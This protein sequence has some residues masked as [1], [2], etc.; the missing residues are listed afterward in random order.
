MSESNNNDFTIDLDLHTQED[1]A[2]AQHPA[3]QEAVT[4]IQHSNGLSAEFD[5]VPFS[6][7]SATFFSN[8]LMITIDKDSQPYPVGPRGYEFMIPA[9]SVAAH[10]DFSPLHR[11]LPKK[12]RTS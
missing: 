7:T 5:I 6:E 4:S 10:I 8:G 2:Q 1:W 12:T 11:L 9:N 3:I